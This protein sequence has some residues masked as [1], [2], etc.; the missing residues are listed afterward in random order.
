[1]RVEVSW[2]PSGESWGFPAAWKVWFDGAKQAMFGVWSRVMVR[3]VAVR[4]VRREVRDSW[5]WMVLE[6][7]WGGVRTLVWSV[8]MCYV[9]P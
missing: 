4:A 5:A 6:Q 1:M 3:F 8:E 9:V 2:S 7:D